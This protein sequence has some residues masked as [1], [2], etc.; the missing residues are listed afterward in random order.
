M[1]SLNRVLSKRKEACQLIL[2]CTDGLGVPIKILDPEG[3]IIF[4]SNPQTEI[5]SKKS[6]I[7]VDGLFLGSVHGDDKCSVIVDLVQYIVRAEI[8]KK[9]MAV[10]MLDRYRELNLLYNLSEKLCASFTL[11]SVSKISLDEAAR[12]IEGNDG[13]IAL[14][15]KADEPPRIISSFGE[16]FQA[17]E[18]V[19]LFLLKLAL[20]GKDEIVND[21]Q[22]TSS[23]GIEIFG[24]KAVICA[25]LKVKDIGIGM[26]FICNT[27]EDSYSA[28]DLKLLNCLAPQAATAIENAIT[29]ERLLQ[30]AEQR[31]QRLKEQ[32]L[33]LQFELDEAQ[34]K[35]KVNEIIET[36]YFKQIRG[37]AEQLRKIIKDQTK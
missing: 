17:T 30:E 25:P 8:L 37:Q 16:R 15:S 1:L 11:N 9:H 3:N 26:I 35:K 6:P 32:I 36:D 19:P 29:Y 21:I 20:R 31:E 22:R 5:G 13:F 14:N 2:S 7:V 4:D 23:E 24:I 12:L 18:Q 33:A 10:E 27:V 28:G 34:Q